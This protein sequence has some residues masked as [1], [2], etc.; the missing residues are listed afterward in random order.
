MVYF[1]YLKPKHFTQTKFNVASAITRI[2]IEEH[3][4]PSSKTFLKS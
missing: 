4:L 1:Y 3:K 2:R